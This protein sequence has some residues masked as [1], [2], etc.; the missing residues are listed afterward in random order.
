MTTTPDERPCPPGDCPVVVTGSGAG[1]LRVSYSLDRLGVRHA[2]ISEDPVA[3]GM[4]RRFPFFQRLLSWTKPHAPVEPGTRACERYDW[5]SLLGD[6]PAHAALMP[7]LMDGTSHFPSRAE[8]ERNLQAFAERTER[9]IR[10]A[11]VGRGPGA[12]VGRGPGP[13]R[14]GGLGRGGAWGS[15][16]AG[17]RAVGRGP[18]QWRA[19]GLGRGGPVPPSNPAEFPPLDAYPTEEAARGVRGPAKV[20]ARAHGGTERQPACARRGTVSG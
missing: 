6:E 12:V 11:V 19:G 9:R 17:A 5:N 20:P 3:G 13:G 15:G 10:G 14:G 1:A 4:F 16:G 18:G 2:L 8:M 7:P